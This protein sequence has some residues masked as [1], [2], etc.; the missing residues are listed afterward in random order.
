M[1]LLITPPEACSLWE[2][3][4]NRVDSSIQTIL[5]YGQIVN[6]QE[7]GKLLMDVD[8]VI[9]GI[10]KINDTVLNGAGSLKVISRFGVGCDAIDMEV[11]K[12][13]RI[14]LT[15]TPGAMA[16][17]VARHT[18]AFI[19]AICFHMKE[20]F[21]NL[22]Q[23]R[24]SRKPNHSCFGTR[25][26]VVGM[27]SIGKEVAKLAFNFGFKVTGFNR[28]PF[29]AEGVER[30][31]SLKELIQK[32]DIISLHLPLTP[33]TRGLVSKEVVEWLHGKYLINMS[34]GLV[35]EEEELLTSLNA[36]GLQCYA[37]DVF[38]NEPIA[39]M[40]LALTRHP[41]VLATPHV[42]AM[43]PDTALKMLEQSLNNVLNCLKGEH[44][45]VHAY[46]V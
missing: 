26:G 14:R 9:L 4:Q 34:R 20:H 31:S 46:V 38:T 29:Q 23:G 6:A 44:Q 28:S 21:E 2:K 43:D 32:S 8:A 39:G 25:L 33:E 18:M 45:G 17:G 24:W 5:T 36:G 42:A 27:G 40:S 19:L 37:T 3:V 7:L 41:K 16:S 10:E 12:K 11:L 30:A 35:V 22:Q 1:R 15:N 13:K